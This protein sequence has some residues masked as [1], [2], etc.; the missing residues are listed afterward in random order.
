MIFVHQYVDKDTRRH[1]KEFDLIPP[2][3]IK[4]YLSLSQIPDLLDRAKFRWM[5]KH[6]KFCLASNG[7]I[8]QIRKE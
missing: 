6:K 5:L 2:C 1:Y 7:H 3:I 4:Q 8:F